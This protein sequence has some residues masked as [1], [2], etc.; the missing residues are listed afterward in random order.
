MPYQPLVFQPG[1][2][3]KSTAYS[4]EGAWYEAEKVRFQDGQPQPIGGWESAP[5]I[6]EMVGICRT[7]L[8]WRTNNGAVLEAFA[9]SEGLWVNSDGTLYDITPVRKEE[10]VSA[11]LTVSAASVDLTVAV[12]SHGAEA[13]DRFELSG[14]DLTAQGVSLPDL[15]T[16]H[17]V[18]EVIDSNTIRAELTVPASGS[19]ASGGGSGTVFLL[20][21]PGAEGTVY[22]PGFGAGSYGFGAYGTPRDTLV[23]ASR[24]RVWSLDT[25]GE[26]LVGTYRNGTP[27]KWDPSNDG[28]TVRASEIPNAPKAD[29]LLVSSPDRHLVLFGSVLP[30]E[31]EIN[32]LCV[33][34]CDQEDYTEWSVTATTTAGYQLISTGSEIIAARQS[35]RQIMI[36]TDTTLTAMQ[37]IG[38]PYT[39]SLQPLDRVAAIASRNAMVEANGTILWMGLNSFYVFDGIARALPCPIK[40]VVF[41]DL[42]TDQSEKFFGAINQ[43]FHEIWWFYASKESFEIDR[44]VIFDY[45]GSTWSYGTMARTAWEDSGLNDY[46]TAVDADNTY[47]L[48]EKGRSADG[49][50]LEAYIESAPFDI[51]EGDN[52]MYV[53]GLVPDTK[54]HGSGSLQLYLKGRR[55]PH[56]AEKVYGPYTLDADT[57]R[58]RTRL[59]VRQVTFRYEST[60]ADVFW[61]G[62]K[63]R[64]DLK[65]QGGY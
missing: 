63:P 3:R 58:I 41:D 12:P 25:W 36:W 34:W 52:M 2:N 20:Q 43:E 61:Q 14:F 26:V 56:G 38:P 53:K 22:G 44:Y 8:T 64:I 47:Y 1:I 4:N 18:V 11:A 65:P 21:S 39:F 31:S 24:A 13:G 9:T 27:V 57:E 16:T 7:K 55:Y 32:R 30:G 62:G 6:G 46:P 10:Q 28:L 15:N 35:A 40:D 49:S 45:V 59:R 50:V 19:I 54:I 60:D 51:A 17:T 23:Q 42:N 48:H 37:Y 5:L 29:A 33:R